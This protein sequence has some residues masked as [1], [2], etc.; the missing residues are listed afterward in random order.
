MS[1]EERVLLR[2]LSM[3]NARAD[4]WQ[5]RTR[6]A[7]DDLAALDA[8]LRDACERFESSDNPTVAAIQFFGAV[9]R[10]IDE[11]GA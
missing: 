1:K 8:A 10:L 3:A 4:R 2:A 11:E 5:Q 9:L 6:A 7:R